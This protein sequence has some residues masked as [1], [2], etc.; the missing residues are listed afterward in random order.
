MML[1]D[2]P[3]A[4][5]HRSRCTLCSLVLISIAMPAASQYAT[6][7]RHRGDAYEHKGVMAA[8][9]ADYRAALKLD[10]GMQPAKAA[11]A[12]LGAGP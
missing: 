2:R 6:A 4:A 9:L 5:S 8:A 12:R 7:Y 11:L 1:L 10:P 3:I